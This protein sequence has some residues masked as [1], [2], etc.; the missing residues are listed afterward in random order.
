MA[1]KSED[2]ELN[3]EKKKSQNQ[4]SHLK[5]LLKKNLII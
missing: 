3:R 2:V 5:A 4:G 1:D